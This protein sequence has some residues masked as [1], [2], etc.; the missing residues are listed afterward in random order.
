[1]EVTTIEKLELRIKISEPTVLKYFYSFNESV[2]HE[3]ALEAIRVGVIAIQSA[4]PSLDTKIVE[5]KFMQVQQT[6]NNY[7]TGFQTDLKVNMEEYFK[8]GSGAVPRSL[9]AFFGN[10]GTLSQMMNQYF[11][12]D[13]GKLQRLIQDH[14]GV[15]SPFAKSL[16]PTNKE[17]VLSKLENLVQT[18][19]QEKTREIVNQFSLDIDNSALSRLQKSLYDKLGEIQQANAAYFA[20][21]KE[22]LGIKAGKEEEA[23]IG[24]EK[25]REFEADLYVPVAEMARNMGDLSENV[26]AIVGKLARAKVG[27][28]VITLG[29]TSG[30]PNQ[31]I[32][33]EV[34]K[35]QGYRL[36][37][38][39]EELK[40]AKENREAS[41]GIFIF[42]KGYEPAEVGD[43]YKLGNDFYI[44]VDEDKLAKKEPL[45]FVDAAYKILRTIL[46]ASK[47]L[48]DKKEI[49]VDRMKRDLQ[50]IIALT[51][52]LSDIHTKASTIKNNSEKILE[53]ADSF[54]REL[55][56]KLSDII[57]RL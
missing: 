23:E 5:E 19:L 6:I 35:E 46:V 28:Y 24:T 2:R 13:G 12:T 22:S 45:V 3:K 43:F 36:K 33:M 44:T 21:L 41:A 26:G 17:S 25:G 42:A 32:V 50:E 9:E 51:I 38:A 52:K 53:T 16:D 30:A 18:H 27:D 1:M 14:V 31:K 55:D 7:L 57:N 49:D 11:N 56:T 39:I 8:M 15:T 29:N 34:K 37:D 40:A 48:E 10:A 4:S 47:R 20:N 54:K